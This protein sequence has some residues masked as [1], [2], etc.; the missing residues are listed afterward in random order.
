MDCQEAQ[1]LFFKFLEGELPDK[2]KEAIEAHLEACEGCQ[3]ER[4]LLSKT[5]R[6]LGSY[7]APKL[8]DNFTASLMQKIH[9]EQTQSQVKHS[10]FN[11]KVPV[12]GLVIGVGAG[13]V[14]L[15]AILLLWKN[16]QEANVVNLSTAPTAVQETVVSNASSIK[17]V[18]AVIPDNDRVIIQNLDILKNADFLQHVNMLKDFDVVVNPDVESM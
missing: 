14:V 4:Y 2:D 13:L 10:W 12:F 15:S 11:F 17:P 6:M 7:Q 16:K 3:K 9:S 1:E 8:P 5:W 18:G